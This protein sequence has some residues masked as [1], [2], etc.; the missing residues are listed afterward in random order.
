[1]TR[2]LRQ[3]RGMAMATALIA[4]VLI[5]A[6]IAGT[7]F[8][9]MQDYRIGRNSLS[10]DRALTVAE[11]GQ[12]RMLT[13]WDATTWN[14]NMKTGDT[15][16]KVFTT[17]AGSLDTVTVTRLRYN[18]FWVVSNGWTETGTGITTESRRR[19]G[20][21]I[22]MDTPQ[23]P[24][25][26]AFTSA[27]TVAL[28][29]SFTGTG[30]DASPLGWSDCPPN[31]DDVAAVAS[32]STANITGS[33]AGCAGFACISGTPSSTAATADAA[34]QA[35]ILDDWNDLVA[36]ANKVISASASP[37]A[38]SPTL[39]GL[40]CNTGD[41]NNWGDPL[42]LLPAGACESYYPTIYISC[43]VVGATCPQGSNLT[44]A[45]APP[46]KWQTIAGGA[47]GGRGQ[48]ILLVDG[49]L[50]I[51]GNF[52][53]VGPVIVKG[54][55]RTAGT[56][57]KVTGGIHALNIGCTTTPC[58]YLQGTS[59]VNYSSCALSKI[60]ALKAKPTVAKHHAWADM[61]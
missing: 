16:K 24:F 13:D 52:E 2:D 55:V 27:S 56:G 50:N 41:V 20:L 30:N 7:F 4:I 48:G 59:S 61:F 47:G 31:S 39:T 1:M 8:V 21:L 38:P 25:P 18:M 17:E 23:W 36:G 54:N 10:A 28:S 40:L 3:R 46:G 32:T 14:L 33:G 34:D 22:R 35:K 12:N 42:R 29:G 6:L 49:N 9:S 44:G 51:A 58:N 19:T 11:Y 57:N 5:G 53:W 15:L 45:G 26:G 60:M 37:I 43:T